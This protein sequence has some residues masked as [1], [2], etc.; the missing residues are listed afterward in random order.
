MTG[1]D[2]IG[3]MCA[4]MMRT[5]LQAIACAA[6]CCPIQVPVLPVK[7]SQLVGSLRKSR[8]KVPPYLGLPA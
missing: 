8:W 5:S 7:G 2:D 6:S 1:G 3:E 4:S